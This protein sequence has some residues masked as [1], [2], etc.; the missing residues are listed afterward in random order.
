MMRL[1][2]RRKD[3]SLLTKFSG[4]TKTLYMTLYPSQN[5]I[6]RIMY[7]LRIRRKKTISINS[8][9]MHA[10]QTLN[11]FPSRHNSLHYTYIEEPSPYQNWNSPVLSTTTCAEKF[12]RDEDN[13]PELAIFSAFNCDF[14]TMHRTFVSKNYCL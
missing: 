9:S 2:G 1:D 4:E 10:V 11:Q 13:H 5:K 8:E 14:H 3:I 7:T 6:R 12:E